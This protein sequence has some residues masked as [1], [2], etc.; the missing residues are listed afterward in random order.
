[1]INLERKYA[2]QQSTPG[3][4]IG[5][6]YYEKGKSNFG[7]FGQAQATA[8]PLLRKMPGFVR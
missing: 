4:A 8:L 2:M 1:M 7:C 3:F 6:T 5:K